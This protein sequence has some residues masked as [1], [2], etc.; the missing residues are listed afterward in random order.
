MNANFKN[1]RR[2]FLHALFPSRIAR[3]CRRELKRRLQHERLED[4]C[5]LSTFTD[6]PIL[7]PPSNQFAEE[8][9]AVM[10]ELGSF[11]D[12]RS[13]YLTAGD[14]IV[15]DPGSA[16]IVKV[17]PLSGAQ[18]LIAQ[19][20][21]LSGPQAVVVD[22]SGDILV[23]DGVP[24]GG[25]TPTAQ[26]LRIDPATGSQ[27]LICEGGL[28][29]APYGMTLDSQGNILVADPYYS[30]GGVSGAI[31]K[32]NP[33]TGVQSVAAV[34]PWIHSPMDVTFDSAGN[35]YVATTLPMGGFN[36]VGVV[37]IDALGN[38][39]QISSGSLPSWTGG[40]V[41]DA[42]GTPFTSEL[43][44]YNGIFRINPSSGAQSVFSSGYPFQDPWDLAI[45]LDGNFVVVDGNMFG[46][47]GLIRVN[48][49][50]GA[51]TVVT[52][53]SLLV[54]P[55]DVA[56]VPRISDA[57][58]RVTVSWGDASSSTFLTNET[59]SLGKL[60]HSYADN[61]TYS[62]NVTVTEKS[63]AG[64]SGASSFLVTVS[65]VAPTA[66]A[67]VFETAEDTAS[68]AWNVLANDH[69]PAGVRDPLTVISATHGAHG[70]VVVN[71]D[72]TVVYQPEP[73]FHGTDQFNY[74]I[75][76]GDG[77]LATGT[78]SVTVTAVNDPPVNTVPGAQFTNEDTLLAIGGISVADVEGDSL[79]TVLSVPSASGTLCVTA[80]GATIT[81]N[82]T[83]TVTIGGT[84]MQINAALATLKYK[85][86]A[87]FNTGSPSMSI[88]LTVATSDHAAIDT[89]SVAIHV[90]PVADIVADS[91]TTPEDKPVT[92]NALTGAG[93][94]NADNFEN[95]ARIVTSVTQAAHG[96]VAFTSDGRITYSPNTDYSGSDS[97]TYTVTSGSVTE[98]ATV[99]V[100]VLSARQQIPLIQAAVQSL[101]N[102]RALTSGEG[103]S[104][105]TK[106]TT[107]STAL[108]GGNTTSAVKTLEAFIYEVKAKVNAG[109][110]TA[111]Q[112]LPL[113]DAAND[114]IRSIQTKAQT[115]RQQVFAD[116]GTGRI[117]LGASSR[118]LPAS[119]PR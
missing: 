57:P 20:G 59:G 38:Q 86:T 85:P 8:S 13:S 48:A 108:A 80:N 32:I 78:V 116:L 84:A 11:T 23:A 22:A 104:L 21:M 99:S 113:I 68:A 72:S 109:R 34:G 89:D 107:A 58:W 98:T 77:G 6:P 114:V 73:D 5:V 71:S 33:A 42:S 115:V 96:T 103:K 14:L 79:V 24:S 31:L 37:K 50:T 60:S 69:D 117:S 101:V 2:H 47:G 19:G 16:R 97:F 41:V 51:K 92:F 110:L 112:A 75:S 40:I 1:T 7:I 4:R 100:V 36:G 10:F 82:G 111:A 46:N 66:V 90:T 106:L 53:G 45:D 119:K 105:N 44:Y 74:T 76:D 9:A 26:I 55:M 30:V 49:V 17:D 52:S 43:Y 27:T 65:N 18:T 87:D 118:S 95:A 67:D 63:G 15:A 28:L 62:V 91:I 25:P 35:M 88:G 29:Q 64:E 70:I 102:S 61:G 81:N 39:S 94:G 93:G 3:Q 54:D 83:S 12:S 56:V